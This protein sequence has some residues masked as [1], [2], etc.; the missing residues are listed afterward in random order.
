MGL[1]ITAYSKLR[2]VGEHEIDPA[3]NEGEPGPHCYY[4]NHVQ[5]YAYTAF[6]RS[7]RGIHVLA[8][9]EHFLRGGC[10]EVTE[11]T[12]THSFRAGSYS[13]YGAW[14]QDL[15]KQFNPAPIVGL[16]EGMQ[17]PDPDLPFY[18]LIWFADNEGTISGEASADLLRDFRAYAETYQPANPWFREAYAD[19]TRAFELA[20]DGGLVD[21]H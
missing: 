6:P 10:F 17:E 20:A 15:A 18:E 13:G 2:Y 16:R 11:G 21:F 19:W 9:D 12:E 4:E 1:D 5:A 14:R 8:T 3:L 7:F